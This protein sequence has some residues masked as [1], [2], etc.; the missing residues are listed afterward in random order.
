MDN[1]KL[2]TAAII[3]GSDPAGATT[4]LFLTKARV[5]H[6]VIDT[7]TSEAENII[8][9][10]FSYKSHQVIDRVNPDWLH[11]VLRDKSISLPVWGIKFSAPNN[12]GIDIP[13]E[14]KAIKNAL[15]PAY[16]IPRSDFNHFMH[17]KMQS[18]L[19][20]RFT[21]AEIKKMDISGGKV[22]L[23][24][25]CDEVE[26]TITGRVIV[27]AD[28]DESKVRKNFLPK[29]TLGA[30]EAIGL[31]GYFEGVTGLHKD[32]YIE[33]HFIKDISP[34]YLWIFPMPGGLTNVGARV[35]ESWKKNKKN[36]PEELLANLI[37]GNPLLSERFSNAKMVG[38]L[39]KYD[40]QSLW[41]QQPISGD[42]FIL[43]G[44]AAALGDTF[45]GEGIGNALISGMHAAE[46]I[47]KAEQQKNYT[48]SFFHDLYD[49]TL[50]ENIGEEIKI[51]TNIQK[52]AKYPV[53]INHLVKK[54][55][56]NPDFRT[57]L[58]YMLT[59]PEQ[60]KPLQKPWFY[61]KLLLG[62]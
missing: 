44:D 16:S 36:T 17:N 12:A 15:A 55:N 18:A 20:R 9:C 34:G 1:Q 6:I 56:T 62:K 47:R 31:R 11:E 3:I 53:V 58:N 46:A 30:I 24:I 4:S 51:S 54:A 60:R 2:E 42:H 27:G 35:P 40:C 13:F 23:E 10:A 26:Y 41:K 5:P 25:V 45:S 32:N 38:P 49:K 22:T 48:K 61:I 37:K 39:Q 33:L 50:F 14:L 28:G 57:N 19:C 52:W 59:D 8:G 21:N 29:S 43:V 7:N